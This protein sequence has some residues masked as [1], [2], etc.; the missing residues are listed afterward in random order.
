MAKELATRVD[1][2]TVQA[3][4]ADELRKPEG[5]QDA[6]FVAS[7]ID[8]L[9]ANEAKWGKRTE[10]TASEAI[11]AGA[12]AGDTSIPQPTNVLPPQAPFNP[13]LSNA[14]VNMFG[15][16]I[17]QAVTQAYDAVRRPFMDDQEQAALAEKRRAE[18]AHVANVQEEVGRR[19]GMSPGSVAGIRTA[20][21]YA[22]EIA[23]GGAAGAIPRAGVRIAAETGLGALSGAAQTPVDQ[24]PA[25]GMTV[26]AAVAGGAGGIM[27][28]PG[29]AMRMA[30]KAVRRAEQ[31]PAAAAAREI[32]AVTGINL[33]P[34]E[35][36]QSSVLA[37]LER[38]VP[39]E[40][41]KGPRWQYYRDSDQQAVDSFNKTADMLNNKQLP[42]KAIVRTTRAALEAAVTARQRLARGNFLTTLQPAAK[43][44][45]A[46]I[47]KAGDITGGAPI[48]PTSNLVAEIRRQVAAGSEG[49]GKLSNSQI[50]KLEAYANEVAGGLTIGGAQRD[51]RFFTD[52]AYS[53]KGPVDANMAA[54]EHLDASRILDAMGADMAQAVQAGGTPG[55]VATAL[56]QARRQYALDKESIGEMQ[57]AAVNKLIGGEHLPQNK[58][59]VKGVMKMDAAEFDDLMKMADNYAPG[60]GNA[61]RGAVL[62]DVIEGATEREA[63]SQGGTKLRL[64]DVVKQLE[65]MGPKKLAAL[66]GTNPAT[67]RR[68]VLGIDALKR[69]ASGPRGEAVQRGFIQRAQD[70][71]I[72]FI[73]QNPAFAARAVSAELAPNLL[74]NL[75][76]TKAGQKRLLT[77]G[78]PG[79]GKAAI[80]T[81]LGS[82]A[83]DLAT[84]DAKLEGERQAVLRNMREAAGLPATPPPR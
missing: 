53:G 5:K 1:F 6:K 32:E 16:G 40:Q 52:K 56:T 24:N 20:G 9:R 7:A 76:F 41:N 78:D 42:L 60:T 73:S 39:L 77:L 51:L 75:L 84:N 29:A 66:A 21:T 4:L 83:A 80:A 34:A 36:T 61:I 79:S 35:R 44:A 74:A 69:V 15:A 23:V 43:A 3:A 25:L 82:I 10:G 47:S 33:T 58:D 28:L 49:A 71:V 18:Q 64:G 48:I 19:I 67:A 68:L 59:F 17:K 13:D 72:N 11:Q 12:L 55:Q 54:F 2:E 8:T 27:E 62:K 38:A 65:G 70:V 81:A 22:P 31:G 63:F 45:G 50:K 37:S 26:G 14:A 30:S 46:T 57:N